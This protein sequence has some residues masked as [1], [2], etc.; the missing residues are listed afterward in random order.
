MQSTSGSPRTGEPEYLVVG[1]LK[2]PHGLRGEILMN[3]IT[4]FPERLKAGTEVFLGERH[5]PILIE[6]R[7]PHAEGMLVKFW[8]LDSPEA[9][10][11][12]RNEVV[13]VRVA[14]RPA[15][16]EGR[17]YHHQL[18]GFTVMDDA[19]HAL[20]AL[21]EILQTGANDVYVVRGTGD[22]EI[23]LPAI[24][25]VLLKIDP[26]ARSIWVHVPAGIDTQASDAESHR[27]SKRRA[28]HAR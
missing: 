19:G 13:Y 16:P 14:D 26:T 24:A 8:N 2:R 15:L 21:D 1:T 9:V 6:A 7:R 27:R 17:Y 12:Y 23:L 3:V 28:A 10:G 11:Q 4:D 25:G 18:L 5:L 22:H 20:G